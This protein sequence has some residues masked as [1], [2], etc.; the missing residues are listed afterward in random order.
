MMRA[1]TLAGLLSLAL[2][3]GCVG[4]EP[5][6][7]GPTAAAEVAPAA[8]LQGSWQVRM[9][10]D[11]A[12]ARFEQHEGWAALFQREHPT[13]LAA[14]AATPPEGRGLA[15]VHAELAAIYTQGVGMGAQAARHVYGTD[16]MPEDP[17]QVDYLLG[18]AAALVGDCAG[19]RAALDRL[20]GA[21]PQLSAAAAWWR[22]RA[23]G[24]ACGGHVPPDAPLPG[25]LATPL[26]PGVDP[27]LP[28]LPVWRAPD[29]AGGVLELAE[30]GALSS[31]AAAHEAAARA[32]APDDGPMIDLLLAP[33]DLPGAAARAVT[34]P[35]MVDDAWLFGGFALHPA[36]LGF[37]AAL[38]VD[39]I[40][41]VGAWAT[42]SALAA[43]LQP[44]VVDGVVQ[45]ERVQDL[46][47]GLRAQ[48]LAQMVATTG[49]VE[50]GYHRPFADLALLSVLRAG[51]LAAD[52]AGQYRDAGV[53]RVLT[54]ERAS[55]PLADPV[56]LVSTAAWDA[57][58]RSPLRPQ[59]IVH[60]HLTR[61]PALALARYPLDALHIRL[62]RTA[63][64]AT[65]LH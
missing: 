45:I 34:V 31:L 54:L 41:A 22:A 27:G 7:E 35:E 11:A 62:G 56:F 9:S 29:A 64:P 59:E 8:L 40:A 57:G 49:G 58:N 14:F 17:P 44:A 24:E 55:G 65:P 20:S 63:A 47:A 3:V 36:D 4:G 46:A 43:T 28:V 10:V 2:L 26:T 37:F 61:F 30:L 33:W 25:V 6:A 51:M 18:E 53:L 39:G 1:P 50:Q 16:R 52:A 12:R 15:R 19:A 32:A 23:A 38:R 42:R 60:A 48:L 21:D 13:A 5:P